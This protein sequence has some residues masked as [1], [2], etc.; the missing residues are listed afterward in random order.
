MISLGAAICAALAS[1][2][3]TGCDVDSRESL[4]R[5]STGSV[6]SETPTTRGFS[7]KVQVKD[8][9]G[10]V[11]FSLKPK[12]DG[13]KLVDANEGELARITIDGTQLKVKDPDDRV[14]GFVVAEHRHYE[15]RYTSQD[16]MFELS[17]D[18]EGD[19][20]LKNAEDEMIYRIKRR[21]YG[22]EIENAAD[23]SLFKIKNKDGKTSLRD[24]GDRTVFS[25]RDEIG[26]RA[27]MPF[28]FA[29]LDSL[30]LQSA[31]ALALELEKEPSP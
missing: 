25:T 28:G 12:D 13:A 5:Q 21:E 27:F 14:L 19:W 23:E 7:D 8:A 30:P 31:V 22:Y 11:V 24:S 9:D 4:D 26:T 15:I 29:A 1:S 2:C 3:I 20:K 6:L 18:A 10:N 16:T 17:E